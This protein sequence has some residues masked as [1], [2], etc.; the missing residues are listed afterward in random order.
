[1][2]QTSRSKFDYEQRERESQTNLFYIMTKHG[3][4]T[5]LLFQLCVVVSDTDGEGQQSLTTVTGPPFITR[6]VW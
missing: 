3:V 5:W 1:M 4:A 2:T 6:S